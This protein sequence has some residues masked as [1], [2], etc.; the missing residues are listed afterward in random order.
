MPLIMASA[1]GLLG[2]WLLAGTVRLITDTAAIGAWTVAG[3]HDWARFGLAAAELLGAALFAFEPLIV[4]GF[5]LLIG[6]FVFAA[7]V[8]VH[9]GKAPWHLALYAL[10]ATVLL[11]FSQRSRD[12]A[13]S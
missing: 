11:Y 12:P 8:H 10:V 3:L 13:H 5:V 1:R 4:A 6:S 9:L 2:G 7:A